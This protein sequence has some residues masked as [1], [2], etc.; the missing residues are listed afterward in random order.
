MGELQVVPMT[1]FKNRL[2][3][4]VFPR[5]GSLELGEVTGVLE[6]ASLR[7]RFDG[8]VAIMTGGVFVCPSFLVL[9]GLI[10]TASSGLWRIEGRT[11]LGVDWARCCLGEKPEGS[12]ACFI[13]EG[14][15]GN[16]AR[17]VRSRSSKTT[18][19]EQVG[20]PVKQVSGQGPFA[21]GAVPD[22]VYK[23]PIYRNID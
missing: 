6:G 7:W 23:S 15:G 18:Q 12:C 4:W 13:A 1:L 21:R 9:L 3:S 20:K 10:E 16:S 5:P 2:G 22:D 17:I 8:V 14:F 11:E 19:Q